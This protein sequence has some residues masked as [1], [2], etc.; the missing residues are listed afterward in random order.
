MC[1]VDGVSSDWSSFANEVVIREMVDPGSSNIRV[2]LTYFS[3][4]TLTKAVARIAPS[5]GP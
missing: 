1:I 5:C 4:E 2:D 3:E